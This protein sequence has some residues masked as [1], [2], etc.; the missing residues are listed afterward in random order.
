MY[1]G[2]EIQGFF[3]AFVLRQ[4]QTR[5]Q[6]IQN[7]AAMIIPSTSTDFDPRHWPLLPLPLNQAE[8]TEVRGLG[9]FK[10]N[11]TRPS[12]WKGEAT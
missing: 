4:I 11:L 1:H 2:S 5:P 3:P 10:A 6:Q 12:P 7:S 9:T 8:R